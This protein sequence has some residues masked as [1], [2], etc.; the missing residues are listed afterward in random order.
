M[1][2]DWDFGGG[3]QRSE[4]WR[5]A[6]STISGELGRELGHCRLLEESHMCVHAHLRAGSVALSSDATLKSGR[7]K[8]RKGDCV[9]PE[10]TLAFRS[11]VLP[12]LR[13]WKAVGRLRSWCGMSPCGIPTSISYSLSIWM[14]GVSQCKGEE[15]FKGR[16]VERSKAGQGTA[17]LERE[18]VSEACRAEGVQ[19]SGCSV[20][21]AVSVSTCRGAQRMRCGPLFVALH[22]WKPSANWSC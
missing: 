13:E 10:V 4:R 9:W 18:E 5:G 17:V 16:T 15:F 11:L 14:K 3:P 20:S 1:S 8:L 21:E 6:S 22:W 7:W 2:R 19:R 12:E